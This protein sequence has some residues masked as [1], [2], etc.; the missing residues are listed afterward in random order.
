MYGAIRL[1]LQSAGHRIGNGD[2]Q[3]QNPD[4]NICAA[5]FRYLGT[6]TFLSFACRMET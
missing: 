6:L 2:A 5:L 1:K 4:F 3:I